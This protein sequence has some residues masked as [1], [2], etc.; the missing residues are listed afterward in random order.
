MIMIKNFVLVKRS[1]NIKVIVQI[2][3]MPVNT[4]FFAL[5]HCIPLH[6]INCAHLCTGRLFKFNSI[7]DQ[8]L[9]RLL[10]PVLRTIVHLNNIIGNVL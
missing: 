4:D 3:L 10:V 2:F 7:F 8:S 5:T 9:P 1:T 6:N